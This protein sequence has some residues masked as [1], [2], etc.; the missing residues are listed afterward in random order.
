[1]NMAR[2]TTRR[3]ASVLSASVAVLALG[4]VA[5]ADAIF[6]SGFESGSVC[7]W[8]D[9]GP[10]CN[11]WSN[12]AGGDWGI[13]N[14]WRDNQVPPSG[15]DVGIDV[16]APPFTIAIT[17]ADVNVH[18]LSVQSNLT[19][20]GHTLT[21]TGP[22]EMSGTLTM[23]SSATLDLQGAEATFIV[24]GTPSITNSSLVATG[25]S[26]L[27]VPNLTSAP[28][29]TISVSTGGS[30]TDSALTTVAG[31]QILMSDP[32]SA[33]EVPNLAT[34]DN[35]VLE[36]TSG[37]VLSLPGVTSYA[38]S[39]PVCLLPSCVQ[40]FA[41]DT[42]S[43]IS[44]PNLHTLTSSGVSFDLWALNNG[45]GAGRINLP[46]LTTINT[47]SN[48]TV[49]LTAEGAGAV[50]DL[51]A[52]PTLPARVTLSLLNGAEVDAG[53]LTAFAGTVSSSGTGNTLDTGAVTSISGSFTVT[54]ATLS[55]PQVTS[56]TD[57]SLTAGASGA[58]TLDGVTIATG[59]TLSAT[60]G[61]QLSMGALTTAP[62]S[63]LS[64]GS[65]GSFVANALTS[66]TGGQ[67]LVSKS[68]SSLSA[69]TLANID[70]TVLEATGGAVLSLPAVTSYAFSQDVCLLPSCVEVFANDLGSTVVLPNVH[71]VTSNGLSFD[72]WAL[73]DGSGV[74]GH[75]DLPTLTTIGTS[76][77]GGVSFT[78]QSSGSIMD[79]SGL[80]TL[81]L[82]A[83]IS[84][85]Y[86]GELDATSLAS[87]AGALTF[88]GTHNTFNSGQL[89]SITGA[90]TLTGV[91]KSFPQVTS[92]TDTSITVGPSGS[93]T[94]GG[95]TTATNTTLAA[96][97]GG[98]L[99]MPALTSAPES[100]V[101]VA[102]AGLFA[103]G[104]LAS[105]S[106][107]QIE[108]S[109]AGSLL[110]V[111]NLANIDNT[112]LEAATGAILSLPSVTSYTLNQSRCILPS[113]VEVF[114]HD[115]GSMIKLA[116]LVTLASSG[117]TL[118]FWALDNGS[119]PGEI[120][121]PSM[122]TIDTS[123]GGTVSFTAQG[124]SALIDASALTTYD[125]GKVTFNPLSGGVVLH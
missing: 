71:A 99:S 11:C 116:N 1:M 36:V 102:S 51:S 38:F 69:T 90:L 27:A 30:V 57:V 35:T 92:L 21:I 56:L 60:N 110:S 109:E 63:T 72:F 44:L 106:S 4:K 74:G 117:E 23:G 48:G 8:S 45:S 124:S 114:A 75:I 125:S 123:S 62:G 97:N 28:G 7:P 85:V 95:V 37:S 9:S 65:G 2:R 20:T 107:G 67:I 24:P 50:L 111:A 41:S 88:T 108:I 59:S 15:S 54:G 17:Q 43:T 6:S 93:L 91:T 82:G 68:T 121:L 105:L 53:S 119:G 12:P 22:T 26:E 104:A 79:L 83:T 3:F 89:S 96:N 87:I 103:A 120:H 14:N 13:A 86:G 47:A 34:I 31:G 84:V 10:H 61:G 16:A 55:Y 18:D 29:V 42:G 5:L 73:N 19:I 46:T 113:C 33:V 76:N 80:A 112:V 81:P 58:L 70:N 98:V 101:L 122:N 25:G 40:V 64:V 118:D 94:L 100:T 52:L 78:S 66:V 49:S 32:G 115:Y 39:K 77:N